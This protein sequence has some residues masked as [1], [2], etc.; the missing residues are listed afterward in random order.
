LYGYLYFNTKRVKRRE[1]IYNS[2][3][4]KN[5]TYSKKRSMTRRMVPEFANSFSATS[6]PVFKST[7]INSTICNGLQIGQKKK[8]HSKQAADLD[9]CSGI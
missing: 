1:E 2:A 8:I 6:F 3:E 4:L 9:P 5:V 7:A